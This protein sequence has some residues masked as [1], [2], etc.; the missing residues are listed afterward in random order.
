MVPRQ[1]SKDRV[2]K[3]ETIAGFVL[4]QVALE[5]IGNF[6]G[7]NVLPFSDVAR[8]AARA[9]T[10]NSENAND[11]NIGGSTHQFGAYLNL[12]GFEN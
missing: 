11:L 6:F 10:S 3:S 5:K 8:A 2:R 1:A 4:F 9:I 12:N 7:R